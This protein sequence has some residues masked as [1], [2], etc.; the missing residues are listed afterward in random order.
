MPL[1]GDTNTPMTFNPPSR[2]DRIGPSQIRENMRI[3]MEHEAINLAQGRPDFPTAPVVKQAA[4]D[5]I[6]HDHNQYSVTWGLAELR[7][8]I[9][10]H[11]HERHGLT[12]DSETE[13]TITCGVTEAIVAAMLAIVE[14]GDEV[15][16][17]EPAH[18]N[19]VPAVYF[20]SGTPRFVTLR[21]PDYAVPLDELR[22]AINPRTRALILNTPHN[23]SGHV[24]TREELNAILA[25]ADQ[26][27]IYVVTDE[28]YD[29]LYY[30][31]YRHIAP[32]ILAPDWK[33]LVVTGGLSKIYAATG[34]RLGYVL[35]SRDVTAAIRT[36]HDYL[37]ICAPTPFQYAAVT[38]LALPETYYIDLRARFLRRRDLTMQMLTDSGFEPYAPQGAY[39]LLAGYGP[40]EHKG[41]SQ[42][43]ATRLIT[44]AKVAVVPGSAFYYQATELGQ[45]LVRFAFAKTS[46]VLKQAGENL[47]QAFEHR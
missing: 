23:P 37:T 13:I 1:F 18:E 30:E 33:G 45:H 22:S 19:Y 47:V 17:I 40:W 21:P 2:L 31:P 36:V 15:I 26:H 9:A 6:A 46:P 42:S 25:L 8:A 5:A 3:A 16:I 35:A 34:W 10:K 38:A 24:F 39:Y 12:V 41:D 14:S 7:E 28:I 29:H 44:E 4:I 43:F 32:S 20:A 11:V 27:G